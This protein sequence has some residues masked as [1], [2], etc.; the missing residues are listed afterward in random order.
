MENTRKLSQIA[1]EVSRRTMED[2]NEEL[3]D[4]FKSNEELDKE[5]VQV[6]AEVIHRLTEELMIELS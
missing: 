4:F 6:L 5:C 1:K 2:I 3:C